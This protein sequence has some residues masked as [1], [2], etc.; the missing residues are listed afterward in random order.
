MNNSVFTFM[1]QPI[2]Q[3]NKVLQSKISESFNHRIGVSKHPIQTFPDFRLLYFIEAGEL[4][5]RLKSAW[6]SGLCL[7]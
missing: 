5:S 6:I 1:V 4:S 3:T 7:R 2:N